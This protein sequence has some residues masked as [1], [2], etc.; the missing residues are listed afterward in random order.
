MEVGR[1]RDGDD[2]GSSRH[3]RPRRGFPVQATSASGRPSIDLDADPTQSQAAS[4]HPSQPQ[5]AGDAR[6]NACELPAGSRQ[7]A[8]A[9]GTVPLAASQ[10]AAHTRLLA[11]QVGVHG[12]EPPG[13]SDSAPP[14]SRGNNAGPLPH[15]PHVQSRSVLQ[16]DSAG[17]TADERGAGPQAPAEGPRRVTRSL[18]ALARQRSASAASLSDSE[19]AAAADAGN[20]VLP[21]AHAPGR[22]SRRKRR[23]L[24]DPDVDSSD[25][26]SAPVYA[27]DSQRT[28]SGATARPIARREP[29]LQQITRFLSPLATLWPGQIRQQRPH[30][31][32]GA[33]AGEAAA[34]Q[35]RQQD[36]ASARQA[37]SAERRQPRRIAESRTSAS[38]PHPLPGEQEYSQPGQRTMDA[39]HAGL[40]GAAQ[41]SPERARLAVAR[42]EADGV[43][44]PQLS[45]PAGPDPDQ[46]DAQHPFPTNAS[47]GPMSAAEQHD[48]DAAVRLPAQPTT[49]GA[50]WWMRTASGIERWAAAH[51]VDGAAEDATD[52]AAVAGLDCNPDLR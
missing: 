1:R 14:E 37:T 40:F 5:P 20:A 18:T 10:S 43:P 26:G 31:D 30:G 2:L 39:G 41:R 32:G 49:A 7:D 9:E 34:L 52:A 12:R 47:G 19:P 13:R 42:S 51:A 11:A 28:A 24:G 16:L 29:G 6:G 21:P 46:P 48:G 45:L 50:T 23:P 35:E 27:N 22:S 8:Q 15:H 44:I 36:N 4:W 17:T 33:D 38:P 25:Q 3:V